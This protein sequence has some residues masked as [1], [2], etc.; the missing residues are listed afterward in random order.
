ENCVSEFIF[1]QHPHQL[2]SGLTNSL[3][4]IAKGLMLQNKLTLSIL[5]VMS[6][7]R[8]DLIL[9]THIPHSETDVFVFNGMLK[10]REL[11]DSRDCCDDFTQ[12][13]L[14]QNCRFTS[15]I[16]TDH[17]NPHLTLAKEALEQIGK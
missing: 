3:S 15:S 4:V 14:V 9:A 5:K 13:E 6:P 12:F 1:I 2:F 17:Q 7:Q 16:Q 10:S 11:T 8:T